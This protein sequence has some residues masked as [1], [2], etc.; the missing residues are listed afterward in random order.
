MNGDWKFDVGET[1]LIANVDGDLHRFYSNRKNI[2]KHAKVIG[3]RKGGFDHKRH[4][5]LDIMR[6]GWWFYE[7]NLQSLEKGFDAED[8]IKKAFSLGGDVYGD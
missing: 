4:Y 7:D 6:G 5:Q 2:G 3:L 1:V 8:I